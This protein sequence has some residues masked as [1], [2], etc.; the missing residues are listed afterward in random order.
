MRCACNRWGPGTT[1]E[2]PTNTAGAKELQERL[3]AMRNERTTQDKMWDTEPTEKKDS[4][5]TNISTNQNQSTQVTK[6]TGGR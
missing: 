2:K 4:L 1:C 6:Y 5:V 3:A